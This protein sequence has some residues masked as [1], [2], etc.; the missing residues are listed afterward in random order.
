MEYL[1]AAASLVLPTDRLR[2]TGRDVEAQI[3]RQV[4]ESV[5]V[6]HVV[7]KLEKRYDKYAENETRRSLLTKDNDELPDAEELGAEVEAFLAGLADTHRGP[8]PGADSTG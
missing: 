1:G 5:E 2:E 4:D 7:S 8:E 6:Q 3:A